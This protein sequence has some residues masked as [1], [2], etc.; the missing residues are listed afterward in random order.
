M[1]CVRFGLGHSFNTNLL[2]IYCIGAG[3]IVANKMVTVPLLMV[4]TLWQRKQTMNKQ[5]R[6]IADNGQC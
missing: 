2:S 3:D 1:N 4:L 6:K 5:A